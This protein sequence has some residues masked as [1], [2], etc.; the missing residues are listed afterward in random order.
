MAEDGLTELAK[1][2]KINKN[3]PSSSITTGFVIA[4]P[5]EAQIRLNEVVILDKENLVFA[6]SLL[7]DLI[8]PGEEVILM[9]VAD[10]QSYYA[11]GKA[12]R[13]T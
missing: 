10:G 9:P 13:F 5:P 8:K 4:P 3:V 11:L 1:L 6:T 2:F 7:T 12:V